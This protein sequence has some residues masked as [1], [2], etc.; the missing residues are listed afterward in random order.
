MFFSNL[1]MK[2]YDIS[3]NFQAHSDYLLKCVIS[4]DAN[5]VATTSADHSIKLWDPANGYALARP[6]L[7]QHQRWVWDLAFSADSSFMVTASSD[8]SAKLWLHLLFLLLM[9]CVV[10]YPNYLNLL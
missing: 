2:D 9:F 4:P 8:Q 7:K 10:L 1:C 5:V 6:P 3:T